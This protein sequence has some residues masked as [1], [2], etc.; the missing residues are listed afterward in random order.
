MVPSG[1]DDFIREGTEFAFAAVNNLDVGQFFRRANIRLSVCAVDTDP[2]SFSVETR[3]GRLTRTT[4]SEVSLSRNLRLTSPGD[5]DRGIIVRS[6]D[7]NQLSVIVISEEFTSSDSFKVLPSVNLP[8]TEYEYYALSVPITETVVPTATPGEPELLQE[9]QGNS[10]IVIV[11]SQPN[12]QLTLTLSQEVDISSAQDI[13]QQ[14]SSTVIN[15]GETVVFTLPNAG[16]TLYLNSLFDVTGS[17]VLSNKP[18]AF[19]TGH[20]CGTLPAEM[21]FCDQM[22]EQIPPTSTWGTTF[23]TSPIADR[24]EPDMFKFIASRDNTIIRAICNDSFLIEDIEL[25]A[26]EI[27]E[28]SSDQSCYYE[29]TSPILVVQFSTADPNLPDGDPFMVVVPPVEQFQT[30]YIVNAFSAP[31]GPLSDAGFH[32]INV[33]VPVPFPSP[34]PFILTVLIDGSPVEGLVPVPCIFDTQIVCAF[35]AAMRVGVGLHSVETEEGG[36]PFG[37]VVY[38]QAFRVGQG[39]PGG[40]RQSPIACKLYQ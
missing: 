15:A 39:Y 12:T 28:I 32:Y 20:E 16:Q 22:V 34:E 17:R 3:D 31:S 35:T 6:E 29:S 5:R 10:V 2:V 7:G 38:W 25:D 36:F 9:P 19:F 8:N 4:P 23:I 14:I 18:I 40:M 21:L 24:I 1:E 13:V 33:M 27:G 30:Q 11:T 26:G 37:V